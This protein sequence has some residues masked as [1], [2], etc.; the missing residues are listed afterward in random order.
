M[1]KVSLNWLTK[2]YG[3]DLVDM[4]SAICLEKWV[5]GNYSVQCSSRKNEIDD[6]GGGC[7]FL[8]L[9]LGVSVG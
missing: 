2:A 7:C 8:L 6:D 3:Y 1:C 4:F 5:E 9:D